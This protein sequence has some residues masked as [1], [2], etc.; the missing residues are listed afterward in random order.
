MT[1]DHPDAF[2][3]AR[4]RKTF[5]WHDEAKALSDLAQ[6]YPGLTPADCVMVCDECR[7]ILIADR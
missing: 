7:L 1:A 5:P 4:C 6:D 3:C 2:A